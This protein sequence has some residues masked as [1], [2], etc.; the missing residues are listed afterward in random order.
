VDQDQPVDDIAFLFQRNPARTPDDF[1][2]HY[3]DTHAVMG[4]TWVKGVNRYTVSLN[5]Q[6]QGRLAGHTAGPATVPVDA[7]TELTVDDVEAFFDT[8]RAF[9]D[10]SQVAT[11]M[12][13]HNS[14][15]GDGQ[16]CYRVERRVVIG[17]DQ[18]WPTTER[19]PG[20]KLLT[21]LEGDHGRPQPG[22]PGVWRSATSTVLAAISPGAPILTAIVERQFRSEADLQAFLDEAGTLP[23]G[24][25]LL[26]EYLQLP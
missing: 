11:M 22:E 17:G 20:V 7:L 5:D 18:D 14:M 4:R 13:D 8:E 23:A 6:G 12:A 3:L 21:L 16:H 26:S 15:F 25:Y 10:P 1:V 2:E 24:S 19:T 9:D